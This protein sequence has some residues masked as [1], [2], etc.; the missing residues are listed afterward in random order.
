MLWNSS[1]LYFFIIFSSFYINSLQNLISGNDN[2][3]SLFYCSAKWKSTHRSLDCLHRLKK[4]LPSLTKRKKEIFLSNSGVFSVGS[5]TPHFTF[6][7][8]YF[9]F[10][11]SVL[12]CA[13]QLKAGTE[14]PFQPKPLLQF[15]S[16]IF[17]IIL[18]FVQ[19]LS[20]CA[21]ESESKAPV[22]FR[23]CL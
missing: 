13:F 7:K 10:S 15:G 17:S 16:L 11:F 12:L 22:R 2:A 4:L 19:V 23:P 20:L 21:N 3:L 6:T 18:P 8:D 1:S 14:S 5:L 9:P